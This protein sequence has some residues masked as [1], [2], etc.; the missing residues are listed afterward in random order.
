[1]RAWELT[2]R[3][4]WLSLTGATGGVPVLGP[5]SADPATPPPHSTGGAVDL[6]LADIAGHPLEMVVRS[7]PSVIS[8]SQITIQAAERN[9]GCDA[10]LCMVALSAQ[11]GDDQ[12]GFAD[13]PTNGGISV[14]VMALGMAASGPGAIYA[15][16]PSS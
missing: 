14:T 1:M 5:P 10:A 15:S 2:L 3:S 9:P 6:T 16:V 7:M 12:A 11:Q 8:P 13:T 4:R